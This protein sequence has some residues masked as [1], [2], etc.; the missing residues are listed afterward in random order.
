MHGRSVCGLLLRWE[1]RL[2]DGQQTKQ[3]K[4]THDGYVVSQCEGEAQ[5]RAG[6]AAR[7]GPA[8]QCAIR[9]HPGPREQ[10]FFLSFSFQ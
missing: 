3:E 4:L 9:W 2:Q 10:R 1:A 7:P 5:N 6:V 8:A